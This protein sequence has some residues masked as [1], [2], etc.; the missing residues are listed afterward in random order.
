[1]IDIAIL[2][3]A[4]MFCGWVLA[5]AEVLQPVHDMIDDGLER[6]APSAPR[7]VDWARYGLG[8][9]ICTGFWASVVIYLATW[10]RFDAIDVI[11]ANAVH[12][13]LVTIDARIGRG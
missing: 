5:E 9:A 4:T 8:C 12:M 6:F 1:M 7:F 11:A 3:F 2:A 13:M 10:P